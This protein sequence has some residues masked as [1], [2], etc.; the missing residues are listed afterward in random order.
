MTSFTAF[1]WLAPILRE[2]GL[3]GGLAGLIVAVS[4]VLQM[5]GSLAA[6]V[7]AARMRSQSVLNVTAAVLT[8]NLVDVVNTR[9]DVTLLA[10]T[11][12]AF[13][14]LGPEALPALLADVPRLTA[15]LTHHVLPGRLAPEGKSAIDL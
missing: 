2:R 7:L 5:A 4:I 9:E 14:A 11:N 1:A 12:A 3:D 8:A 10:P 13:D 6:P 15:L